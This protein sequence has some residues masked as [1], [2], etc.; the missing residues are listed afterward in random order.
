MVK[1]SGAEAGWLSDSAEGERPLPS[2]KHARAVLRGGNE[3]VRPSRDEFGSG[4]GSFRFRL[5]PRLR[6]VR[7]KFITSDGKN[8]TSFRTG[9]NRAPNAEF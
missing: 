3:V 8:G 5:R 6:G 7:S 2:A 1:L 9:L 4:S